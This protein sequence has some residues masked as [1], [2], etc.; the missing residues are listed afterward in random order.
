MGELGVLLEAKAVHAGRSARNH[1]LALAQTDGISR[2]RVDEVIDMVGLNGVA[3][4]R[5]GGFSLGMGQRLGVASACL[6][7]RQLQAST[8]VPSGATSAWHT[9]LDSQGLRRF[10]P[11]YSR[12]W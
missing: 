11:W 6:D 1:L 4:R 12:N 10:W 8:T 7:A 9:Q 3:S 2:Q 5:V